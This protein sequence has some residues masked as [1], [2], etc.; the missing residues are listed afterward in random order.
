MLVRYNKKHKRPKPYVTG[1][2]AVLGF[3]LLLVLAVIIFAQLTK[4][5]AKGTA[6]QT[7]LT[8]SSGSKQLSN[9][10][11]YVTGKYA[12]FSYPAS[13]QN[14]QNGP[15][16][17]PVLASYLYIYQDIQTWQLAITIEHLSSPQLSADT[18]YSFRLMH[19]AQYQQS[20][21]TVNQKQY[22]IMTDTTV[23]GFA[24]VAYTLSGS[25]VA[26]ISL[27][28]TDLGGPA[29]LQA[30]FGTVLGSWQWQSKAVENY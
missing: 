30:V 15:V 24:E 25:T 19:P 8:A 11:A 2:A 4:G 18:S 1:I 29:P 10:L 21:L 20:K 14:R 17:D 9:Q 26:E 12:N 5:P 16:A 6:S 22:T 27:T 7:V 3:G 28:G 13:M 23:S